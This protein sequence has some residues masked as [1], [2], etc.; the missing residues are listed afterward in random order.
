MKRLYEF[1]NLKLN[2]L[3]S[4]TKNFLIVRGNNNIHD[5]SMARES[6]G[7]WQHCN[8]LRLKQSVSEYV[9]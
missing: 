5:S 4:H 2:A 3:L 8:V 9:C 7:V 6:E 1:L